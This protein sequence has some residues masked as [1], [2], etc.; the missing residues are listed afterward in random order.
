MERDELVRMAVKRHFF[1]W[2]YNGVHRNALCLGPEY[3]SSLNAFADR[4][5]NARAPIEEMMRAYSTEQL[6]IAAGLNRVH[7]EPDLE[8]QLTKVCDNARHFVRPYDKLGL[9]SLGAYPE[10]L[11]DYKYWAMRDSLS[12]RELVWLSIGLEPNE[13]SDPYFQDRPSSSFKPYAL[14]KRESN[15]RLRLFKSARGLAGASYDRIESTKIHDWL[16]LVDLEVPQGFRA[17][18]ECAWQRLQQASVEQIEQQSRESKI[19]RKPE[20]REM[21]SMAKVLTAI[22]VEEFGYDIRSKRSPIP[23]EIEGICDRH[24]LS[25]SK[26]TILKYLRLGSDLAQNG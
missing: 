9:I 23:K 5:S 16:N 8:K 26:E 3:K 24:G 6:A 10:E 19:E 21:R 11:A 7:L 14:L 15:L 18:L 4:V 12:I 20:P 22:A 25:V 2:A 1:D 17:A 13:T